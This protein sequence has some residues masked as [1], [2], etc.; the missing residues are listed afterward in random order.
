GRSAIPQALQALL[1]SRDDPTADYSVRRGLDFLGHFGPKN[2]SDVYQILAGFEGELSGRDLTWEVFYSSGET[3]TTN[4]YGGL[5]SI[6][7]WQAV[8]ALPEFGAGQTLAV[9]TYQVTCQSGLPI[10]QGTT[11]TMTQDCVNAIIGS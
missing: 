8:V 6:Q 1:D 2:T 3:S 7:K 9:G 10:F 4:F 11:A 5:P